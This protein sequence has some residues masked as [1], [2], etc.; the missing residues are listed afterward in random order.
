M[1]QIAFFIVHFSYYQFVH[2]RPQTA[3]ARR[4]RRGGRSAASQFL[5]SFRLL[6]LTGAVVWITARWNVTGFIW[7]HFIRA[8]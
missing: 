8:I 5:S 4:R 7:K 2:S 3:A 6:Y 1:I